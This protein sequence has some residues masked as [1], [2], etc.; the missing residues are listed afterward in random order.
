MSKS[1]LDTSDYNLTN[2]T[3]YAFIHV[4]TMKIII[5]YM[6]HKRLA[7]AY[8]AQ[9]LPLRISSR[10]SKVLMQ[11][12]RMLLLRFFFVAKMKR[13]SVCYWNSFSHEEFSATRE[14]SRHRLLCTWTHNVSGNG[15][16][17]S[18]AQLPLAKLAI[19]KDALPLPPAIHQ[20]SFLHLQ[21]LQLSPAVLAG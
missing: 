1:N 19:A 4:R 8:H 2:L 3:L 18:D 13:S 6:N 21:T 15:L 14:K 16:H 12:H 17:I 9:N 5:I 20:Q 7:P 11:V 10:Y